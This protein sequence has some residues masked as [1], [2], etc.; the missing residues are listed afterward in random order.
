MEGISFIDHG[1]GSNRVD[2]Y[3]RDARLLTDAIATERDPGMIARYTFYLANTLRDSGQKEA[4]LKIYLERARL[5]NWYQEVFMSLLHAA[6]LKEELEYSNDE[7]II[8]YM[9]ATTACPTRAEALHG[10]A[11]FCRNKGIYERGYQFA[12]QGLTIAYP[13]D[14]LFIEDWVYEYG[15]LDE[16]AINAY[17]TARYAECVDVCDRLLGEGK[18]PSDQRERVLKNKDFATMNKQKDAT[19]LSSPE[20]G[21]FIKLLRAAQEKEKLGRP[22]DEVI[23]A[24]ME[25]TAACPTRAEALHGAARFCRIRG[26]YKRGYEFAAQGLAIHYP[27]KAPAVEDWIY[28][29]G[30]HDEFAVNAYWI[31]RYDDCLN[32]CEH[33]LRGSNLP[34][35]MRERIVKNAGFARQN[36][37]AHAQT[38]PEALQSSWSPK[39]PAAGTELMV[40]GLRTQMGQEIDRIDLRVNYPGDDIADGRPRV[41]WI[42]HDVNQQYMQWCLD[43]ARVDSVDAFVFVSDWQRE[44]YLKTFGLPPE[45]CITL[46]NATEVGNSPRH[47][48]AAPVWRCAYTSTP[49]RGL[50]V[51]LDAWQLLG[52]ANAELHIWSSMRLYVKDDGPYRQLYERA[53]S[54]PGVNYHG[55]APNVELRAA[56]RSM[57][58]LTYPS[59]FEETSCLSVIEAMAAGCRVI[60][61]SL[62]ALPETTGQFARLYSFQSDPA[63]HADLFAEVLDSEIRD[64]WRGSPGLADQQQTYARTMYDWPVR[65]AEWQPFIDL[66]CKQKNPHMGVAASSRPKES[67]PFRPVITQIKSREGVY[68]VTEQDHLA[69]S[70]V[71]TGVWE[72]HLYDFAG[73]ILGD[74]SNVIDL[75][76]N[77]G[78]HT[79]GLARMIPNGSLFAFE[80]LNLCFS[81]LQMNVLAN[82]LRNVTAFKMAVTD[83]TGEAIEMEPLEATMN[84]QGMVNLGH[85][86]IGNGGDFAFTVRLDDMSFPRIDFIKVDVQGSEALCSCW[87]ERSC[88]ERQTGVLH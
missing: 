78:Y 73:L 48:K 61:P 58:F 53:R 67:K 36:L 76:A 13:N 43:K 51:L 21:A 82:S 52:P 49:F 72:P 29:Y 77:F 28:E 27:H 71:Q 81:Q 85:T 63:A 62:G 8:A 2:K 69:K 1:T 18:L 68:Y 50:S 4:A 24:Y 34:E 20:V 55:I 70:I 64:P 74:N 12:V 14:A 3:E 60:C 38:A 25:T 9:E 32:A 26:L 5:G 30:L 80:P 42:H 86:G 6:K 66:A 22:D 54:I 23:S 7:V 87:N 39:T 84:S 56:L 33:L 16:L 75:G 88:L 40:A 46:R 44:R 15:L 57:H 19:A 31:E 79:V 35:Y 17:W 10:A 83:R 11:R 37:A 59:T 47:W 41:V 65:I 45:R